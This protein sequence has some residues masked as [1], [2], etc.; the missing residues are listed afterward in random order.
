MYQSVT[1]VWGWRPSV[2]GAQPGLRPGQDK[3]WPCPLRPL[4]GPTVHLHTGTPWSHPVSPPTRGHS[5]GCGGEGVSGAQ[6]GC[7]PLT[8][9]PSLPPPVPQALAPVAA[10]ALLLLLAL[11]ARAWPG[12]GLPRR[13]CVHCC[14]PAWPPAAPGPHAPM[15]DGEEWVWPPRVQPT[16]DISILKGECPCSGHPTCPL[17]P[18]GHPTLRGTGERAP[19]GRAALR[20]PELGRAGSGKALGA[21]GTH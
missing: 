12:L 5:P 6:Q 20:G 15:S 9:P 4:R 16:I 2:Q 11:P 21:R 10:P 3:V 14:R 13:P 18:Q 8:C 7:L 19:E 17:S 1:S